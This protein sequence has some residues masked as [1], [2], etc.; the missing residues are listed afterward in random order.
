M[1]VLVYCVKYFAGI[2]YSGSGDKT[3]RLW[4]AKV[5]LKDTTTFSCE[6]KLMHP[7]RG[8][9]EQSSDRGGRKFSAVAKDIK[10]TESKT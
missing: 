1:S 4:D 10:C 2:L 7:C 8:L 5:G 9:L 6:R 3:I